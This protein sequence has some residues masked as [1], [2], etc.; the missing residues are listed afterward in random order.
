MYE[1]ILAPAKAEPMPTTWNPEKSI[2]YDFCEGLCP[3]FRDKSDRTHE[4]LVTNCTL[5][6]GLT[7]CA[8][9]VLKVQLNPKDQTGV[10]FFQRARQHTGTRL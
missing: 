9:L 10:T 3:F 6:V 8:S 5:T 2:N 1:P 4:S 7:V